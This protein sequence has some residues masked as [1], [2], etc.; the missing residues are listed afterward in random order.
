MNAGDTF[1]I[2]DGITTHLNFVIAVLADG[3]LVICHFTTRRSR[4]DPTCIVQTGEHP[5][6]DRETAIRYDQA[7]ICTA[8]H[9]GNLNGVITK[10]LEALSQALLARIR[11]GA[12][13]SPQTP[14]PIK[15]RLRNG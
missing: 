11:Q 9:I 8:D 3:S 4:S 5:F 14:D 7:Y 2:P 13:D 15:E 1:L 10:Q 12:L 6:I